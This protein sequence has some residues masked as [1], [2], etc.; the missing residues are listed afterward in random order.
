[1]QGFRSSCQFPVH[2]FVGT[3]FYC[4]KDGPFLSGKAGRFSVSLVISPFSVQPIPRLGN[5]SGS[6]RRRRRGK[7]KTR[8]RGRT[9]E[10]D[11]VTTTSSAGAPGAAWRQR[12]G[13][14]AGKVGSE[15]H[16][17][18]NRKGRRRVLTFGGLLLG[19]VVAILLVVSATLSF[20]LLTTYYISLAHFPGTMSCSICITHRYPFPTFPI[21]PP[22]SMYP[23]P[24]TH[25]RP[26]DLVALLCLARDVV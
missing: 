25:P 6:W 19:L 12:W 1:M 26:P 3:V 8:D 15:G 9:L 4:L 16:E 20:F 18:E 2:D 21:L 5:W 11:T 10:T 24:Q 23:L 13:T 7:A 14:A 17:V 22:L